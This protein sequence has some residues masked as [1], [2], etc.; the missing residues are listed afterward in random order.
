M[1]KYIVT[2]MDAD[3]PIS[4]TGDIYYFNNKEEAINFY[5]QNKYFNDSS[6]DNVIVTISHIGK[7]KRMIETYDEKI[8]DF[9]TEI[10]ESF[11]NPL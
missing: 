1:D 4:G 8:D 3:E 7:A 6:S 10:K 11:E 2:V 9:V 5:E